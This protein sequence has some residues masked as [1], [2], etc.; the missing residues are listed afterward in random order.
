MCRVARLVLPLALA[1]A[2]APA[3]ADVATPGVSFPTIPARAQATADLVPTGWNVEKEAR[4]DLSGD[5]LPD[6]ALVLRMAEPANV[7]SNEGLGADRLDTNPRLLV[8]AFA[9]AQTDALSLALADHSLIPRHTD[10]LMEDPFHGVSIVRGTLQVSLGTSMSAGGWSVS[11]AKLTFRHQDG[12]FRLIGYDATDY[13]RNSGKLSKLSVN[14]LTR[15]VERSWGYTDDAM[16]ET[17][18]S[19]EVRDLPCLEAVGNGL[20]FQPGLG[21]DPD[22]DRAAEL[23]KAAAATEPRWS[24]EIASLPIGS[25]DRTA[26]LTNVRATCS[27]EKLRRSLDPTAGELHDCLAGSSTVRISVAFAGG[28][29]ASRV[30][31]EDEATSCVVFALDRAHFDDLTCSFEASLASP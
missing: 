23:L 9:D 20:E 24:T 16:N 1:S 13:Q 14:Y 2:A 7:I 11:N 5:G 18:R 30:E 12:C 28:Q 3:S 22:R 6:V 8:V 29:I 27:A 25:V 4:G 21:S 19:F 10:P 17:R 15:K 31:P 26:T